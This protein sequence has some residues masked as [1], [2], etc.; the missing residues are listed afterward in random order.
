MNNEWKNAQLNPTCEW[1][2]IEGFIIL[3]HFEIP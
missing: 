2:S 1:M 3:I